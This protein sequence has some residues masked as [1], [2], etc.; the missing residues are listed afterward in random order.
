MSHVA[1]NN[2]DNRINTLVQ[3]IDEKKSYLMQKYHTT[4]KATKQNEFLEGVLGDYEN[5]RQIIMAQKHQQIKALQII[6]HHIQSVHKT[7][8]Y[9]KSTKEKSNLEQQRILNEINAIKQDIDNI[10]KGI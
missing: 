2:E 5:Y 8:E 4:Y 1:Q 7:A 6:N 10:I 3:I 9:G